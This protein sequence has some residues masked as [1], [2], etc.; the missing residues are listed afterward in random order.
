V[1][2]TNISINNLADFDLYEILGLGSWA[3]SVDCETIKKAYHKAVLLYHPDKQQNVAACEEDA[4]AVFLKIQEANNTLSNE[5]KRRAYDSQ[6]D[7]DEEIPSEE[8]AKESSRKGIDAFLELFDPVF[9][10]NA[11][12]AVNK[13]VPGI[14]NADTPIAQVQRFYDY[15]V[16]FDSWRDFTNV[17]AEHNVDSATSREEKRWMMKENE[18]GAKKLKKKEMARL[19]DMVMRAMNFDPRLLQEKD[20][21]RQ[22]KQAVK[23]AKEQERSAALEVVAKHKADEEAKVE[24]ELEAKRQ[25]KLEW[26]R[27]KKEASKGR[28]TFRKLLRARAVSSDSEYGSLTADEVEL[29]CQHLEMAQIASLNDSLG[30]EAALA[31]ASLLSS[32]D[33]S[34]RS[35]LKEVRE[36]LDETAR[37]E[38]E[39]LE[40]RRKLDN[41]K[42][43]EAE[44]KK[45]GLTREWS[46]EDLSTLSKAIG[47]FPGGM[48]QRWVVIC[49]YMNDILKPSEPFTR[50]ECMKAAHNA[51][52]HLAAMKES[53]G[54]GVQFKK[55]GVSGA[56]GPKAGDAGAPTPP[57]AT[58]T[59]AAKT[60]S[61]AA[62]PPAAPSAAAEDASSV[63]SQEQQRLLE[64]GLKKYPASMDKAERWSK[65][66]AD[67][68]GKTRK[69]CISRYK[70][71]REE[72]QAKKTGS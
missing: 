14:G 43:A 29:L 45:K 42:A 19:S 10:R 72:L 18:R 55:I 22:E 67:V 13:P 8:E 62:P 69:D 49:N 63:W 3:S 68:P 37:Q 53:G 24:A 5:S 54:I 33:T 70:Q 39:V 16:N 36:K 48:K 64:V 12:F 11:R 71:L 57:P 32:D 44:L 58:A 25:Q 61:V 31:D 40:E 28:N 2:P 51:M 20:R 65:I 35:S 60:E 47:K 30:G 66:A 59:A 17:S 38:E 1:I 50:D 56:A 4:R 9:K 41:T 34:L 21:L 46:R 27:T 6:L 52:E 15:W 23:D 7:F 26:E